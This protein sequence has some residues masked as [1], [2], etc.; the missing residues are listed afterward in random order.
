MCVWRNS[1]AAAAPIPIVRVRLRAREGGGLPIRARDAEEP[2]RAVESGGEKIR[3]KM[4]GWLADLCLDRG[5][6][7]A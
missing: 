2:E 7:T 1:V 6:R 4:A 3:A 5:H